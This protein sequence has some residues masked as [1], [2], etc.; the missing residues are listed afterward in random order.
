M[1]MLCDTPDGVTVLTRAVRNGNEQLVEWLVSEGV[2]ADPNLADKV[3]PTF[4]L[5]PLS[6]VATLMMGENLI[7]VKWRSR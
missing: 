4:I 3:P 2:K 1:A 5:S 7:V 6:L